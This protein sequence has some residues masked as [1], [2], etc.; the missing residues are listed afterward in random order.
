MRLI[1]ALLLVIVHGLVPRAMDARQEGAISPRNANYTISARLDSA[2]R[3]IP[4]V[5]RIVWRNRTANPTSDLRLHLYWNAWRDADSTWA[6]GKRLAGT[7]AFETAPQSD[8]SAIDLTALRLVTAGP[9][10][11]LIHISEPTRP[12]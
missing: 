7:P 5:G 10:L 4:G 8:R 3:T 11:S 2:A 1:A 6:R 12:Y 9:P